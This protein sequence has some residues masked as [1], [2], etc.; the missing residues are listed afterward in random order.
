LEIY[1]R[2]QVKNQLDLPKGLIDIEWVAWGSD[3]Q[4]HKLLY[5]F[6]LLQEVYESL[7]DLDSHL[8]LEEV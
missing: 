8:R 4:L 7:V 1:T 6:S 3:G 5:H 2:H